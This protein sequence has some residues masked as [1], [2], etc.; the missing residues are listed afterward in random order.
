MILIHSM[1]T[2]KQTT[3]KPEM[4]PMKIDS[5]RKSRSSRVGAILLRFTRGGG[6]ASVTGGAS[7]STK[8]GSVAVWS[9]SGIYG[10][11]TAP[12]L[13]AI[14]L[15]SAFSAVGGPQDLSAALSVS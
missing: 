12:G 2:R 5:T 15:S 4:I 11:S 10:T 3:S 8:L 9:A 7:S 14:L 6:G 1:T 13:A